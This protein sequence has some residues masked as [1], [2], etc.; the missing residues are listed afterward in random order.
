M[1]CDLLWSFRYPNYKYAMRLK[2][3]MK[4]IVMFRDTVK[5]IWLVLLDTEFV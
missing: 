3:Q 5:G 4:S 1:P 2:V